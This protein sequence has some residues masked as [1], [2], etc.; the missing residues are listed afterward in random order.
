MPQ[1]VLFEIRSCLKDPKEGLRP[2]R[3]SAFDLE[4]ICERLE[5]LSAGA[6]ANKR[7]DSL[8]LEPADSPVLIKLTD[9]NC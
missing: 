2:R 6:P 8:A 4:A 1:Q 3:S 5:G 9:Y 7:P